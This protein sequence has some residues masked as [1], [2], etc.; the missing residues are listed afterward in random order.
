MPMWVAGHRDH[1][2]IH[3]GARWQFC[4]HS[5]LPVMMAWLSAGSAIQ[6]A[7]LPRL[8]DFTLAPWAVA[9]CWIAPRALVPAALTMTAGVA[10]PLMLRSLA[11][12]AA[13]GWAAAGLTASATHSWQLACSCSTCSACAQQCSAGPSAMQCHPLRTR[14]RHLLQAVLMHEHPYS[15]LLRPTHVCISAG[16]P[17]C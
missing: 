10:G 1:L 17:G 16:Q 9:N 13:P 14:H 8:R 2:G 7:S 6:A 11:K 5:Q 3:A 15:F 12:S 4:M